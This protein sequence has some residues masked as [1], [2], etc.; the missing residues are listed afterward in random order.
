MLLLAS[1]LLFSPAPVRASV[2]ASH[3]SPADVALRRPQSEPTRYLDH[4]FDEVEVTTDVVYHTTRHEGETV[5]LRLDVYQPAG[6]AEEARPAM[7][8]IHGGYFARGDKEDVAGFAHD[9]A[10]RG[11]VAVSIQ[12]RLFPGA[13]E[14]ASGVD[15]VTWE[16]LTAMSAA[17]ADAQAAVRWLRAN[18]STLGIDPG[19]IAAGGYSAGAIT[20]IH[21]V[22]WPNR[23]AGA[24]TYGDTSQ[25]EAAVSLA[26]TSSP[27]FVEHGE[28]GIYMAHG[29]RDTT[30]SYTDAVRFCSSMLDRGNVCRLDTFSGAH[31]ICPG[32]GPQGGWSTDPCWNSIRDT[33]SAFLY[34]QLIDPLPYV[35]SLKPSRGSTSGRTLVEIVGRGL[36]DALH[37]HVGGSPALSVLPLGDHRLLILTP[38]ASAGVSDVVVA[39]RRGES[40]VNSWTLFE[41]VDRPPAM[42][43]VEPSLIPSTGNVRMV[44]EGEFLADTRAVTVGGAPAP[45]RIDHDGRLSVLAPARE[46]GSTDIVVETDHG[47]VTLGGA[48]EYVHASERPADPVQPARDGSHSA[49]TRTPERLVDSDEQATAGGASVEGARAPTSAPLPIRRCLVPPFL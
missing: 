18:A 38:A 7:V 14:G 15:G 21:T 19:R 1:T 25:V 42:T 43:S 8:W 24:G 2:R 17:R 3:P 30:V 48:I 12:Y 10:R 45:F 41:H 36:R 13:C 37:V 44:L 28:T 33:Y 27:M 22:V 20:A 39:N 16:C 26:G 23:S 46:P 6:D 11:Y 32:A 4:V 31:G 47:E 5:Q 34:D 40:P 29:S 49:N 35:E 9:S